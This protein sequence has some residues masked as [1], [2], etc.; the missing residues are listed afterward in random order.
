MHTSSVFFP[1][2]RFEAQKS[3]EHACINIFWRWNLFWKSCDVSI[4]FLW[5][6][7]TI[8]QLNGVGKSKSWTITLKRRNFYFVSILFLLESNL[9]KS[10]IHTDPK[11]LS[12]QYF[13][14]ATLSFA[15]GE[16]SI[17]DETSE[18]GVER[19]GETS[20]IPQNRVWGIYPIS[21]R[22]GDISLVWWGGGG[23]NQKDWKHIHMFKVQLN[24]F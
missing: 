22:S 18:W 14:K 1:F 8:N 7:E 13:S 24:G 2:K 17:C 15:K 11:A 21:E 4:F 9:W 20:V 16:V 5:C 23:K 6:L 12:W 10:Q 3:T 19:K